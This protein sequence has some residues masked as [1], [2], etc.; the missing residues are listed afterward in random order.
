MYF[1]T[2]LAE[3]NHLWS[4]TGV[5]W[6][7]GS[8]LDVCTRFRNIH[9]QAS[10]SSLW[11]RKRVDRM[12]L[13]PAETHCDRMTPSIEFRWS[14]MM[15]SALKVHA[16][17]FLV[18]FCSIP[19]SIFVYSYFFSPNNI[20]CCATCLIVINY[21]YGTEE[22]RIFDIRAND[23]WFVPVTFRSSVLAVNFDKKWHV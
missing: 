2:Y 19:A 12:S 20:C 22:F 11:H 4:D 23:G 9:S 18:T 14:L 8:L 10:M 3:L 15:L 17:L 13:P 1:G 16:N 21:A 6:V 7:P 5:I